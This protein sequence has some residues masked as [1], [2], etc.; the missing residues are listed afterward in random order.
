MPPNRRTPGG[1]TTLACTQTPMPAKTGA[2]TATASAATPGTIRA[3]RLGRPVG[4]SCEPALAIA[5]GSCVLRLAGQH[6]R[7]GAIQARTAADLWEAV[8]SDAQTTE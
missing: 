4:A 5:P 6:R 7:S 1:T 3:A 2:A 8:S